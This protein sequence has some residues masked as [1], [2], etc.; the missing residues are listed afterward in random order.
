MFYLKTKDVFY[1]KISIQKPNLVLIKRFENPKVLPKETLI[2]SKSNLKMG[3]LKKFSS[4][5]FLS[6]KL[7]AYFKCF[8]SLAP[9]SK[10]YL[11]RCFK[12]FLCVLENFE[13]RS[14]FKWRFSK[15]GFMKTYFQSFFK[16]LCKLIK[17]FGFPKNQKPTSKGIL[18]LIRNYFK[19]L[20]YLA[21]RK[22]VFV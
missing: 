6:S 16:M 13:K 21:K 18:F 7:L 4:H 1:L 11:K 19:S 5:N 22:R 12:P 2:Y 8:E 10:C 15:S 9:I 17:G 14:S 20:P 3:N